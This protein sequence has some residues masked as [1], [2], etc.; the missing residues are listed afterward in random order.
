[1]AYLIKAGE[2]VNDSMRGKN[3]NYPCVCGSGRKIKKCCGLAMDRV[4]EIQA[5]GSTA[6]TELRKCFDAADGKLSLEQL[7][8]IRDEMS[9]LGFRNIDN[10]Q[11][12][13]CQN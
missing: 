13:T 3:R 2:G 5:M 12:E 6:N 1:M 4:L 8:K 10:K 11:E 7:T 9:R